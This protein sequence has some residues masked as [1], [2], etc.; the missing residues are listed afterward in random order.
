MLA[1]VMACGC[2]MLGVGPVW[3]SDSRYVAYL[4]QSGEQEFSIR[5]FE[6]ETAVVHK[7]ETGAVQI[8]A[9][10]GVFYCVD[11]KNQLLKLQ[12]PSFKP[13]PVTA[14]P[15]A[16]E[17]IAPRPDGQGVYCLTPEY[18]G[19]A[20]LLYLQTSPVGNVLTT[21]LE[22]ESLS[23]PSVSPDGKCLYLTRKVN[24]SREIAE[25]DIGK[26]GLLVAET[27]VFKET[28]VEEGKEN[29]ARPDPQAVPSRDGKKLLVTYPGENYAFLSDAQGKNARRIDVLGD[30]LW[31]GFGPADDNLRFVVG[32]ETVGR[33]VDVSIATGKTVA[34]GPGLQRFY[35]YTAADPSGQKVAD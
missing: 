15:D 16:V 34:V 28:P 33:S 3:S 6:F 27:V 35:G 30:V 17:S 25:F 23:C 12:P 4:V 11:T 9:G 31:A 19:K 20:T 29:E 13:E 32:D 14:A 10:G 7:P 5:V 8:A 2:N 22:G 26:D 21:A 24:Q 1:L 18:N